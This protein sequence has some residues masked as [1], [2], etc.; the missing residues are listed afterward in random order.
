M[1]LVRFQPNGLWAFADTHGK[2]QQ[3]RTDLHL[4][5]GT[6]QISSLSLSV[7]QEQEQQQHQSSL[8]D[9]EDE[10]LP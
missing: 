9:T 1:W 8:A 2:G 4:H 7:Q 5:L 3:V 6:R 10:Y